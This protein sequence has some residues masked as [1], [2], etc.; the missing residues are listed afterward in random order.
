[1]LLVIS[2][3][4]TGN[5]LKGFSQSLILNISSKHNGQE[6]I[7]VRM[8]QKRRKP[9]L[10]MMCLSGCSLTVTCYVMGSWKILELK[11]LQEHNVFD[12]V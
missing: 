1:M 6:Q 7:L 4:E 5:R 9:R 12:A 3:R 8:G 11:L 10:K 2:T